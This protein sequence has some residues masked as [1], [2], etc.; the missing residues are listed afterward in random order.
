VEAGSGFGCFLLFS[1]IRRNDVMVLRDLAATR[2]F[3][4]RES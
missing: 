4:V 1:N 2:G 3:A